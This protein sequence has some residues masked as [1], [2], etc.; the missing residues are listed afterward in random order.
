MS[1]TWLQSRSELEVSM[2]DTTELCR[3]RAPPTLRPGR[4]AV[5]SRA[6]GRDLSKVSL[7]MEL[8]LGRYSMV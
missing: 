7:E 3:G 1:L 5:E 4:G 2:A 6:S 8:D